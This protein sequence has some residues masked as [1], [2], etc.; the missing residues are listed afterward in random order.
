MYI[1]IHM[2]IYLFNLYINIYL[3]INILTY[4]LINLEAATGGVVK[5]SQNA[6][7]NICTGVSFFN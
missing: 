1:Y 2:Y 6:E 7:E 4:I 5:I 3:Y